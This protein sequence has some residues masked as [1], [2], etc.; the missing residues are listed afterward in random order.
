[1][2][3]PMLM[4]LFQLVMMLMKKAA[5]SSAWLKSPRWSDIMRS[6]LSAQDDIILLFFP[7][8]LLSLTEIR[9]CF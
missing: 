1:M 8:A 7:A 9:G 3:K 4:K 6:V 2:L 5:D